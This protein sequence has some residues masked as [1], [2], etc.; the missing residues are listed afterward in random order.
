MRRSRSGN[1]KA[2]ATSEDKATSDT[3][4]EKSDEAAEPQAAMLPLPEPVSSFGAAVA[5]GWLY[6][7]S[8]HTGDEHEHSAA[9][10]SQ[11]FRR[12]KLEDGAEWEDLPMQTP[13][14]GLALVSHDG[15]V[16]RVGGLNAR[17]ATKEDKEDLHSTAEFAEFDP[18]SGKWNALAPLPAPRSSHNAVVIGDKV[19]CRRRLAPSAASRPANGS[20]MR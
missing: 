7:Y 14:Q 5:D 3:N 6:V 16:Y 17:N 10:L 4:E 1:A 20:R 9:N 19:V 15:K 12:I 8:G 18:A 2:T 13:L 11:H